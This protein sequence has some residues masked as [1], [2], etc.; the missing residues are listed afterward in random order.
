MLLDITPFMDVMSVLLLFS[1]M[2]CSVIHAATSTFSWS[3][4]YVTAAPNGVSRLVIGVNGEFPPPT[5]IVN[6]GDVVELQV[7]N[8]FIDGEAVSLHSHGILQHGTTYYD[9]VPM[10]TQWYASRHLTLS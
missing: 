10:V 8:D 9:G 1:I 6:Q 5:I 3:M 4:S 7:T 2:F